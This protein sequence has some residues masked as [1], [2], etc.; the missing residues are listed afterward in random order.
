MSKEWSDWHDQRQ[1]DLAVAAVEQAEPEL[2]LL[3]R[4]FMEWSRSDR[5]LQAYTIYQSLSYVRQF[6]R[7][8]RAADD[9][10]ADLQ[11]LTPE[12]IEFFFIG[13]S[14][15][16][17]Y[18]TR[19]GFRAVVRRWLRFTGQRGWTDPLLVHAVPGL[20]SYRLAEVV[21]SIDD[22]KIRE[23]LSSLRGAHPGVVRDR[24]ILVLLAVYG[25]RAGHL[26]RLRLEHVQWKEHR[27]LLPAHK[28]GKPVL[29]T[30]IP[31]VAHTL[32]R[33][34]RDVR[35]VSPYP[36]VFLTLRE[37]H[38]PLCASAISVMVRSRL[39][40]ARIEIAP[41]GAHLFRHAFATRLLRQGRSLK[42][43]A[44][45]LG[46]RD[47]SSVAIYTKVDEPALQEVCAQWPEVLE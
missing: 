21:R 43:I 2:R 24:A 3:L 15:E 47:M 40:R 35:P 30:L 17:R 46:H 33:Y 29:H 25:A 4:E 19:R 26:R 8:L 13:L 27:L 10:I 20:R 38:T 34:V 5:G 22:E 14:R 32:A 1:W 42:T 9:P 44:D 23:L 45:L 12:K 16:K 18:G 37:P 7:W 39:A 41:T 36:E 11:G 6:L 31:Q 28:G